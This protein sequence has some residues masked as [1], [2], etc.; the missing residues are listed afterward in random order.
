MIESEN[1]Q[2]IGVK[3]E[4]DMKCLHQGQVLMPALYAQLPPPAKEYVA[5][6][7]QIRFGPKKVRFI[8]DKETQ[9]I[10]DILVE[11]AE[12]RGHSRM[13]RAVQSAEAAVGIE[14]KAN[15]VLRKRIDDFNDKPWYERVWIAI[16]KGL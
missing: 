16:W 7:Q 13:L 12:A 4:L 14:H 8:F 5:E 6:I 10:V 3:E 15:S 9:L 11:E 1:I 2:I